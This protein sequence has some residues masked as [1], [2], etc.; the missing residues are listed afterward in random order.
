MFCISEYKSP[1]SECQRSMNSF[2]LRRGQ[3]ENFKR[4]GGSAQNGIQIVPAAIA[5]AVPDTETRVVRTG[6]ER[7][8]R[9]GQ[10]QFKLLPGFNREALF[11][12]Q[13]S[14]TCAGIIE[15]AGA[16]CSDFSDHVRLNAQ[17]VFDWLPEV[18]RLIPHRSRA[19]C[20]ESG[21][22]SR[23][24]LSAVVQPLPPHSGT[25]STDNRRRSAPSTERANPPLNQ[26]DGSLQR[27]L[28]A[29]IL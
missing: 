9:D 2:L 24:R 23:T 18:E 11:R 8:I 20:H 4:E 6:R 3:L 17:S 5:P 10:D 22:S 1:N 28:T 16:V 13:C 29:P 14:D 27:E 19:G 25:L 7:H 21:G 12:E 26:I 15:N